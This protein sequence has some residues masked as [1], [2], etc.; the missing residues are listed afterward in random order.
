MT[1]HARNYQAGLAAEES[2]LRHYAQAGYALLARRW[3]GIQGELDLV[4][5]RGSDVVFVEVKKSRNFDQAVAHLGAAQS[6]RIWQTAEQF[7]G[8]QPLGLNT[9]ARVDVA[10]VNAMGQVRVIENALIA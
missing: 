2:A 10:L 9:P 6:A 3:R 1:M 8:T 5:Q 4:V 7:L